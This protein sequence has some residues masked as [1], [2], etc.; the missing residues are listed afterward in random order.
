MQSRQLEQLKWI[1]DCTVIAVY[2][3]ILAHERGMLRLDIRCPNDLGYAPWESKTLSLKI[4]D[5]AVINWLGWYGSVGPETIDAIRGGITNTLR[6][7]INTVAARGASFPA[8][9]FSVSFHSG[10]L[11]EVVCRDLEIEIVP[12]EGAQSR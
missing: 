10:S 6:K 3:G 5:A 7:Q 11:L 2:W 12:Q 4:V 9:E 8:I 1:H